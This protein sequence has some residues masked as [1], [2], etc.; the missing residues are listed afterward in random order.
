MGVGHGFFGPMSGWVSKILCHY[1]GVGHVF[2]G[3]GTG[4][5]FPPAH[6]PVLFDQPL[7]IIIIIVIIIIIIII[8]TLSLQK[9]QWLFRIHLYLLK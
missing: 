5:S 8:I 7:I 9:Q 4:F 6:P 3:R 2:L 1:E